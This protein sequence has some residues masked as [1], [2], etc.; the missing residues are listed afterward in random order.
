MVCCGGQVARG[1]VPAVQVKVTFTAELF[2]PLAF[3]S[4]E[5]TGTMVGGVL[6]I[7]SVTLAVL[8]FAAASVS[9]PLM[10]WFAPSVLTTC[11]LG[12]LV[13]GAVEAVQVKLTVTLVLF[14]PFALGP[15]QATATID[16]KV[17]STFN[18][19]VAVAALPALSLAVPETTWFA[20]LAA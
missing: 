3:G 16:G 18:V 6:P 12:Q 20:P 17:S 7:L 14:Q 1:A 5:I 9:V 8:V 15:G 2:Q 10:T 4:G 13:M 11:G 19:N